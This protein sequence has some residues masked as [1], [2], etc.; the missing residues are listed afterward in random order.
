LIEFFLCISL[1]ERDDDDFTVWGGVKRGQ[2]SLENGWVGDRF[3]YTAN[4]STWLPTQMPENIIFDA[5]TT[6]PRRGIFIHFSRATAIVLLPTS[7]NIIAFV[8]RGGLVE[9]F[10]PPRGL[11]PTAGRGKGDQEVRNKQIPVDGRLRTDMQRSGRFQ[12]SSP[13]IHTTVPG[14]YIRS[15]A[16]VLLYQNT[17]FTDIPA[18]PNSLRC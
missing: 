14:I 9:H 7:S 12:G 8:W 3:P 4:H 10:L 11:A 2:P 16:L 13:Y 15:T 1:R 6:A 5:K 18:I 17:L